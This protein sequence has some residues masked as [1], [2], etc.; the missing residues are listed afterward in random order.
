M[1]TRLLLLLGALGGCTSQLEPSSASSN[2][3]CSDESECPDGF[4]CNQRLGRCVA[5]NDG[6]SRFEPVITAAFLDDSMGRPT[7][8]LSLNL[9]LEDLDGAGAAVELSIAIEAAFECTTPQW[10]SV[11]A[12]DAQ[13][14]ALAADSDGE[15]YAVALNLL[16][17]AAELD[18]FNVSDVEL[19][20]G[21]IAPRLGSVAEFCLRLVPSDGVLAGAPVVT[22]P[23]ALGNTAATVTL[24]ELAESASGQV[25]VP[26]QLQ[27]NEIDSAD[28]EV[29]FN[30][31]DGWRTASLLFELEQVPSAATGFVP[32]LAVWDSL[33]AP[34]TDPDLGQGIGNQTLDGV[35]V[36]VRA[37]DQPN[38]S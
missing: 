5:L 25:L 36:R 29:E 13:T 18:E 33:A 14:G 3:T 7:E 9:T 20:D 21:S 35:R 27:D 30:A 11:S 6:T 12:W 23:I 24:G 4:G 26:I 10:Q 8:S 37:L 38:L 28:L 17:A 22:Q 1:N 19:S 16:D 34:M 15:S 31:G 2:I 32:H